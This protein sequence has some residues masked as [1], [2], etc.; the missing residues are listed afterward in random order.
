MKQFLINQIKK[1]ISNFIGA[2]VGFCIFN[3]IMVGVAQISFTFFFVS[4]V[5]F[6]CFTWN[7]SFRLV[8][9]EI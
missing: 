2:W 3:F 8:K 9:G 4:I 1:F 5:W 7:S 6:P